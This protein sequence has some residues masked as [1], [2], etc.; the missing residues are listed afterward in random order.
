MLCLS[1]SFPRT[2]KPYLDSHIEII[3]SDADFGALFVNYFALNNEKSL[4][5]FLRNDQ[6]S[7]HVFIHY[8]SFIVS[9]RHFVRQSE[10]NDRFLQ[11]SDSV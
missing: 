2:I 5:I 6:I 1:L 3:N 10:L 11:V 4:D 9:N 7:P 8:L